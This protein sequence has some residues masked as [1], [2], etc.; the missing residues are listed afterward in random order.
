MKKKFNIFK[1]ANNHNMY[2]KQDEND[3]LIPKEDNTEV[4]FKEAISFEPNNLYI[5][6]GERGHYGCQI[7]TNVYD[8]FNKINHCIL[9]S[10][11]GYDEYKDLVYS[12]LTSAFGLYTNSVV[13]LGTL[14]L[15]DAHNSAAVIGPYDE[16]SREIY[17]FINK[18]LIDY[19]YT[20]SNIISSA[21]RGD[22]KYFN[23]Y[24]SNELV[25]DVN[26]LVNE[27]GLSI[28]NFITKEAAS[29]ISLYYSNKERVCCHYEMFNKIFSDFMANLVNESSI[30]TYNLLNIVHFVDY[31]LSISNYPSD[32]ES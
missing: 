22:R 18:S 25:M 31:Y 27:I 10:S 4:E 9:L 24:I 1:K 26:I 13:S 29:Y 16:Y 28:Y 2:N 30:F 7:P 5:I 14:L 8:T 20:L 11:N 17:H 15:Y 21:I 19:Q 6:D 3:Y 12:F 32:I 23:D